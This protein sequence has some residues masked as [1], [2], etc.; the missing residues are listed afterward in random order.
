MGVFSN[1]GMSWSEV[2]ER[3]PRTFGLATVASDGS[4][5]LLFGWNRTVDD[6]EAWA[7]NGSH[8]R[9][10][11]LPAGAFGGVVPGLAVG[12]SAGFVAMGSNM[13]LR[14]DN[15]VFWSGGP[16]GGWAPEP[17]PLVAPIGE[18]TNLHCP[19]KPVDAAAFAML[20]IPSA[21]V[22]FGRAPMTFYCG[23]GA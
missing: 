8:W 15:P 10:V 4:T 1:G 19:T 18:R 14:A 22:C 23:S 17:S 16:G 12:S 9:Q 11:P 21:V 13:N 2:S 20:D 7:L 3:L 6:P 5:V